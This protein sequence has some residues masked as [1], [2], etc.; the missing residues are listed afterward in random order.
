VE[1]APTNVGVTAACFSEDGKTVVAGCSNG[2]CKFYSTEGLRFVNEIDAVAG[3][4]KRTEDKKKVTGLQW[5]SGHLLVTTNDARIRLFDMR[6]FSLVC[7]YSGF[8]NF[9]IP[10]YAMLSELGEYILCGSEDK[11][12]Y[13]WNTVNAYGGGW[14][15]GARKDRNESYESYEAHDAMVTAT[16]WAPFAVRG[17]VAE[18]GPE[19]MQGQLILSADYDGMIKVF[20]VR[21][22]PKKV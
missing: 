16:C 10:L 2:M 8:R 14:F 12:V 1:W 7:K 20:E 19:P 22:P 21:G 6:D 17:L 5:S 3:K 15:G 18:S 9:D 4:K 11:R 13:V